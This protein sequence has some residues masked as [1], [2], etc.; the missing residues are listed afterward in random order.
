[1]VLCCV[2][3]PVLHHLSIC[4]YL[5][6]SVSVM[7]ELRADSLFL[8]WYQSDCSHFH[9]SPA[10][11]SLP[12]CE[13]ISDIDTNHGMCLRACGFLW[14][15]WMIDYLLSSGYRNM[16]LFPLIEICLPWFVSLEN[17]QQ[18]SEWE[19]KTILLQRDMVKEEKMVQL[20]HTVVYCKRS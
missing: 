15:S 10:A 20:Q 5:Y 18:C 4:F 14:S 6:R 1:M 9:L 17:M 13:L 8:S 3:S 12:M 11:A 19:A 2:S 16:F 7:L